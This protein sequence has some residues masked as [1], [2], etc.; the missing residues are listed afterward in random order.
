MERTVEVV[1]LNRDLFILPLPSSEVGI[2]RVCLTK[3][4]GNVKC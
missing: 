3:D 2:R 4:I 1:S